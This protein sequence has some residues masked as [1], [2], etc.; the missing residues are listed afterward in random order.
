[1]SRLTR[2]GTAKLVSR[3]EVVRRER[4]QENINFPCSAGHEQDWQPQPVDPY[5]CYMCHHTH[6]LSVN[7]T[8]VSCAVSGVK[9]VEHNNREGSF[10][11]T[12]CRGKDC[13]ESQGYI[14]GIYVSA[15]SSVGSDGWSAPITGVSSN[16]TLYIRPVEPIS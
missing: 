9:K 5:A 8:L 15:S 16:T 4:G 1:M 13:P 12:E 2:E 7:K 6:M 3:D 11:S 10:S 14:L